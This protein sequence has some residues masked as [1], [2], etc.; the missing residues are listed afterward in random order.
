VQKYLREQG[1]GV[2]LRLGITKTGCS[3]Y[4]Y[5]VNYAEQIG[6]NDV[7]FEDRGVKIV[8]D[9]DALQLIDGTQ[10][11]FVNQL[12]RIRVYDDLHAAIL[13]N[14][15]ILADLLSIV[16]KEGVA[17]AARL[18]DAETQAHARALLSQVLLHACG[19]GFGQ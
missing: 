9:P 1:A 14:D 19:S 2:G 8:V 18:R 12:Q 16:D 13:E 17:R 15:V 6:Q 5:V 7:V 10:V 3:G 4:S 11:D